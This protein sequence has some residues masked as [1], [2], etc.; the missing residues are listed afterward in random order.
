MSP[1]V[2]VI[3]A[4]VAIVLGLI[5]GI[6]I[7]RHLSPDLSNPLAEARARNA[8]LGQEKQSLEQERERLRSV[9]REG[10]DAQLAQ[11]RLDAR[12]TELQRTIEDKDEQT[13]HLGVQLEEVRN[14]L[15]AATASNA[16]LQER[17]KQLNLKVET[18]ATE[19]EALHK[20]LQAEFENIANR[21]L[22]ATSTKLTETSEKNR[23]KPRS[24]RCGAT[25]S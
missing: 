21:L 25:A 1:I 3:A 4:F 10:R 9:E 15:N 18:Q 11:A 8:A 22:D 13:R 14:A 16:T 12:I 2:V 20:K 7:A 19:L 17:E 6:L 23:R 5:L 24:S